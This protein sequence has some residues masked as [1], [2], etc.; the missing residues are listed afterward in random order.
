MTPT[1]YVLIGIVAVSA[2]VG[3]VRGLLREAIALVTWIAALWCAWHFGPGLE[4]KL[5]GLLESPSVR[6]WAARAIIFFAVLLAGTLVAWLAGYLARLSLVISV[7]RLFGFLFGLLR[8]IVVI[9]ALVIVGQTLELDRDAWWKDAKLRGVA[10]STA[11]GLR[12]VVGDRPLERAEALL[13]SA[14]GGS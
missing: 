12:A 3:L 9:G 10:E 6:P 13:D 7:D 2:I 1:D 5:G 4:P 14:S 11:G 8:G